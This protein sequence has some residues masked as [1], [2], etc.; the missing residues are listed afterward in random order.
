LAQA[1]SD[2]GGSG[3]DVSAYIDLMNRLRSG[4]PI[5][6]YFMFNP[7]IADETPTPDILN[8]TKNY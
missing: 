8:K 3:V 2:G 5:E 6:V 7:E 1:Q 4:L